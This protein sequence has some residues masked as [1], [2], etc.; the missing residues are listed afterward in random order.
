[1]K[2]LLS[3]LAL[4]LAVSGCGLGSSLVR[5][6]VSAAPAFCSEA[7]YDDVKDAKNAVLEQIPEGTDKDKAEAALA[8]AELTT[9]ALCNM[10]KMVEGQYVR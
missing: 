5:D 8:A 10:V 9:E 2:S 6:V 1:M 3:I 4:S 7:D